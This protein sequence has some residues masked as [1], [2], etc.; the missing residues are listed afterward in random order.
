MSEMVEQ[1][2]RAIREEIVRQYRDGDRKK[3]P[4]GAHYYEEHIG[5]ALIARAAIEAMREPTEAMIET[6]AHAA[7]CEYIGCEIGSQ[8]D[9]WPET[10]PDVSVDAD[11]FRAC[12]KA[13]HIGAIGEA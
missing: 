9:V 10:F 12:A 3:C 6:G 13:C 7:F 8:S 2:A 5:P 1:V 11:I 4:A